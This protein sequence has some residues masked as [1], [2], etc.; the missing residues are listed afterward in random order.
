MSKRNLDFMKIGAKAEELTHCKECSH[1]YKRTDARG[2]Y[3]MCDAGSHFEV[4]PDF[5]C[6]M[7]ETE[8]DER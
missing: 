6:A 2:S 7:G 5:Y 4:K 1:S 8:E 3:L